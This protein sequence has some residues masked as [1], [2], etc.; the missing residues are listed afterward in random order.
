MAPSSLLSCSGKFIRKTP[1]D[2]QFLANHGPIDRMLSGVRQSDFS[3]DQPGRAH[4]ILW[5]KKSFLSDKII[6]PPKESVPLVIVGGGMSGIISAYLLRDLNPIVLESGSRFGGNSRGESWN[7]I[8]YSIGAAY[9]MEQE[10]G[11][12][13]FTLFKE[14]GIH[15]ICRTKQE[16]DPVLLQGKIFRNFWKGETSP[17]TSK[18]FLLLASHFEQMLR[19]KNGLSLPEM[20]S[21]NIEARKNVNLLDS[22]SFQEYLEKIVGA[23]LHPHIQTFLEHYCWSTLGA[24]IHELSAAAALNEFV[25]EFGLSYIAPGGNAAVAEKFL[26]HLKQDK[27]LRPSSIVF[28]V[29]VE[30]DGVIVSYEDSNKNIQCI[31]AKAA[32]MACPK[33]VVK[34][35]LQNIE[36]E[37]LAAIEKLKYTAYLVGNVLLKSPIQ[38]KFYDM[39][40]LENG[41]LPLENGRKFRVTDVVNAC[42]SRSSDHSVLTLYRSLPFQGG[43]SE[44]YAE[45]SFE[46]YRLE[47]LAQIEQEILPALG[48]NMA[49]MADFRLT[50]WGHP[51]PVATKGLYRDGVIDQIRKPFQ[52]RVFFVEQDN[53]MLPAIETCAQEAL[54]WAPEVRKILS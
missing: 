20:P 18:Q 37:R 16:E 32:I 4:E 52:K 10:S 14:A 13:L 11:S 23:K 44:I 49:D 29:K 8:D 12:P 40:L 28:D 1:S 47:F 31:H 6:P 39:Y 54:T 43:R 51:M 2:S 46:K 53:W 30:A 33:F 25:S 22:L 35:V 27:S 45:N 7:G 19:G 36:P 21:D 41:K 9:F 34:K 48:K 24:E 50:R 38:E 42:F 5:N 17:D 26:R 15:E 3:G